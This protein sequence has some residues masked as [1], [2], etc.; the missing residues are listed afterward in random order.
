MIRI[1]PIDNG[2]IWRCVINGVRY[3]YPAGQ[4]IDVPDV[5]A[6]IIDN[7]N[8]SVKDEDD[9]SIRVADEVV[10][11]EKKAVPTSDAVAKAIEEGGGASAPYI[12]TGLVEISSDEVW[13]TIEA[14][15]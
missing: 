9:P 14:V 11:G 1:I 8:G 12:I 6:A 10:A 4:T 7:Y 15:Q 5:I 2:N 13:L 3:A